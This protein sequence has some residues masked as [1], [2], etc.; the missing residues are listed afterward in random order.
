MRQIV[1]HSLWIGH[2]GD[3]R[4][5]RAILDAGIQAVVQVAVE[6][7]PLELPR[8][9]IYCRFPLVDGTGNPGKLLYLAATTVG[10]LLEGRVPLL[11]CCSGGMSRAPAIAAAALAMVYQEDPHDTLKQIAERQPHDVTP[12][13][14]AEVKAMVDAQRG[15]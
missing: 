15:V 10:N 1:P 8:D 9:L 14:W 4:E 3:G 12:G 2:A 6:E 11:V 13:F 7:P 5:P